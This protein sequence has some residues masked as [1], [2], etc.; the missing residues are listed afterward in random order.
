MLL[1]ISFATEIDT[2]SKKTGFF[3]PQTENY[4]DKNKYSG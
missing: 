3:L 4:G 1:K 2:Y